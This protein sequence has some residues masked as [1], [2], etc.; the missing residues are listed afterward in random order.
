MCRTVQAVLTVVGF[1]I[2]PHGSDSL[3]SLLPVVVRTQVDSLI[4][5]GLI[6]QLL[7]FSL[8]CS[9]FQLLRHHHQ[10]VGI[11]FGIKPVHLL[12][13]LLEERCVS[14]CFSPYGQQEY[15]PEKDDQTAHRRLFIPVFVELMQDKVKGLQAYQYHN[16]SRRRQHIHTTSTSQ[17]DGGSHP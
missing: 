1:S 4:A 5:P 7:V 10:T 3:Q 12:L 14:L 15:Q 8:Q 11:L 16:R 17:T 13:Q 2:V 6:E 9:L